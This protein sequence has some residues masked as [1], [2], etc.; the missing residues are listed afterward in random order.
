MPSP[1]LPPK[2]HLELPIS[3][4]DGLFLLLLSDSKQQIK[5]Q[6]KCLQ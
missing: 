4:D 3:E 5:E 1:F 2:T 6:K